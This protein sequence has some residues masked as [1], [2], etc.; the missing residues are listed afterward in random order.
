MKKII[1]TILLCLFVCT[2]ALSKINAVGAIDISI[3]G[4]VS[5]CVGETITPQDVTVSLS[6]GAPDYTFDTAISG[7]ISGWFTNIPTG[8]SAT[9][10]SVSGSSLTVQFTGTLDSGLSVGTSSIAITIPAGSIIEGSFPHGSDESYVVAA[11][12]YVISNCSVPTPPTP[13]PE[14]YDIPVTGIE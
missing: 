2:F 9:V 13:T 14:P 6:P 4:N 10:T 12:D 3:S 11:G 1:T 5:G 8:L 7:D